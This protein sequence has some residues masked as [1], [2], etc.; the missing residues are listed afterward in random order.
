MCLVHSFFHMYVLCA[1]MFLCVVIISAV[2]HV[3]DTNQ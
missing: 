3:P 2:G 1:F